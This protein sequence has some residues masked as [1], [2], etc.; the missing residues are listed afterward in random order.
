MSKISY[1]ANITLTTASVGTG[2]GEW[3]LTFLFKDLE[4]IN[5]PFAMVI[6]DVLVIDTSDHE[7]GTISL[8]EII[9]ITKKSF[10]S[11][12]VKV[13]F[14]TLNDNSEPDLSWCIGAGG[15]ISR[16]TNN[17]GLLPVTSPDIQKTI[18]K[19]SFYVTNFNM[20][21]ILDKVESTNYSL[22]TAKNLPYVLTE[23]SVIPHPPIGGF[24]HD[25]AILHLVGG[26]IIEVCDIKHTLGEDGL[27]YVTLDSA[28][29]LLLGNDI[30]SITVTYLINE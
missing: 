18:D 17:L 20:S 27:N 6:G 12:E 26:G 29:D 28:D 22:F 7:G 5:N 14:S 8:Y 23:G 2:A 1:Q 13:V 4:G 3:D 11:P 9:E 30:D 10:T 15:I 21:A 25:M 24:V 19:F 16:P